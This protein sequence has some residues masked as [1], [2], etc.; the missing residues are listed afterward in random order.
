MVDWYFATPV[1]NM[2]LNALNQKVQKI[3]GAEGQ[4]WKQMR[5]NQAKFF[6]PPQQG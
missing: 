2:D 5:E 6:G 4:N 3:V 1:A